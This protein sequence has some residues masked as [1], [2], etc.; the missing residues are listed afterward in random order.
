MIPTF[1]NEFEAAKFA[2]IEKPYR[3]A[4]GNLAEDYAR[5][6]GDRAA[7]AA[8]KCRLAAANGNHLALH[9][10]MVRLSNLLATDRPELFATKQEKR[11][12]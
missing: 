8:A 12:A 11:A 9:L 1:R 10:N 6:Y 5:L 7:D 2:Q 4:F 3:N